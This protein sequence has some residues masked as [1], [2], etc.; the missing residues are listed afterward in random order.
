MD[1]SSLKQ[2]RARTLSVR[3]FV[4]LGRK[5]TLAQGKRKK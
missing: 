3:H 1:E 5:G 4:T 2:V